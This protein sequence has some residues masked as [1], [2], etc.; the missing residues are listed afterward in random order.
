MKYEVIQTTRDPNLPWGVQDVE[1]EEWVCLCF[2]RADAYKI[3]ELLNEDHAKR[4]QPL[5]GNCSWLFI[6]SNAVDPGPMDT[7]FSGI[8]RVTTNDF[9]GG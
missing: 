8:T 1:L 7:V 2:D 5:H 4:T 6:S 3:T 9:R